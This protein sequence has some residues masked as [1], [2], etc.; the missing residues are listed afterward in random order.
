MQICWDAFFPSY[1]PPKMPSYG[2]RKTF[3]QDG[4]GA[5]LGNHI[6]PAPPPPRGSRSSLRQEFTERPSWGARG[7]SGFASKAKRFGMRPAVK[8]NENHEKLK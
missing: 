3:H 8:R 7:T 4:A 5:V 2:E 6:L 1:L